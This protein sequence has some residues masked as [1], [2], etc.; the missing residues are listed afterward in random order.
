MN[1]DEYLPSNSCRSQKQ[2]HD[3]ALSFQ[4]QNQ[5]CD[6][7]KNSSTSAD[8]DSRKK[9]R[10]TEDGTL[11]VLSSIHI[12]HQLSFRFILVIKLVNPFW[13]R[14]STFSVLMSSLYPLDQP[15]LLFCLWDKVHGSVRAEKIYIRS[16]IFHD[17]S[18]MK[19]NKIIVFP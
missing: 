4:L 15:H 14:T 5:D 9:R 8:N 7:I 13:D 18:Y 10:F 6:S 17:N 11:L 16:H 3:A 2:E 1:V 12:N 19:S